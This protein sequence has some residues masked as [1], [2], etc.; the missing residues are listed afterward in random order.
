M[1]TICPRLRIGCFKMSD[2]NTELMKYARF[3]LTLILYIIHFEMTQTKVQ[4]ANLR[5]VTMTET[6]VNASENLT[7]DEMC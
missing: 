6:T 5:T 4:I 3:V 7:S 1:D 2:G